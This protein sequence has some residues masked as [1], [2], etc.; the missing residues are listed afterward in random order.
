[1]R[2]VLSLAALTALAAMP[3]AARQS[4][5]TQARA[6][7]TTPSPA[8]YVYRR[9]GTPVETDAATPTAADVTV[10]AP[11]FGPGPGREGVGQLNARGSSSGAASGG[12]GVNTG[13]IMSGNRQPSGSGFAN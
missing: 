6:G 3:A 10:I 2:L 11:G 4:T 12:V 8:G 5:T 1:M 13:P 9:L 7:Y